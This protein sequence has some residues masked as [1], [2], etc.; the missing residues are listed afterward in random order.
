MEYVLAHALGL[1]QYSPDL[2]S[3]DDPQEA[4]PLDKIA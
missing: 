1:Q 3:V 2:P 4:L